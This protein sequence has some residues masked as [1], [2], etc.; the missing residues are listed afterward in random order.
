MF[1]SSSTRSAFVDLMNFLIILRFRMA[2]TLEEAIEHCEEKACEQK[3]CG[4]NLC[5]MEHRQ[6]AEWLK[7]LQALRNNNNEEILKRYPLCIDCSEHVRES[8]RQFAGCD[9]YWKSIGATEQK[10][11]D[12]DKAKKAFNKVCGWLSHYSW[13]NKVA[14][15]FIKEVEG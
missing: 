12:I 7:E 5:S 1:I 13:F 10:A 8:R 4:N 14:E 6:L 11:I 2:M 9:Y 3:A 15:E